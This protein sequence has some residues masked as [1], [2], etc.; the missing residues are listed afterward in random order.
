MWSTLCSLSWKLGK[1]IKYFEQRRC[2]KCKKITFIIQNSKL[3][4]DEPYCY[5]CNTKCNLCEQEYDE[6]IC[7]HDF[8]EEQEDF[9]DY[10]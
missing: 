4:D 8:R 6:C 3:N 10:E 7:R 9:D 1:I 2:I 5:K